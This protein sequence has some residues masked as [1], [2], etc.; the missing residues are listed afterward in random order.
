MHHTNNAYSATTTPTN[1]IYPHWQN[2]I[3]INELIH[4]YYQVFIDIQVF[5]YGIY[6]YERYLTMYTVKNLFH[7]LFSF[8]CINDALLIEY[9]R[10][11]FHPQLQIDWIMS[12]MTFYPDSSAVLL[13]GNTLTCN[14]NTPWQSLCLI[15]YQTKRYYKNAIIYCTEKKKKKTKMD[16][17]KEIFSIM[18]FSF[19]PPHTWPKQYVWLIR[20]QRGNMYIH[21]IYIGCIIL[22]GYWFKYI[23]VDLFSSIQRI[24]RWIKIEFY[25][26]SD[27][28]LVSLFISTLVERLSVD[29]NRIG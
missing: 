27:L 25:Q 22:Y 24:D 1:D 9:L 29:V 2:F 16:K 11:I 13:W 14:V 12:D 4:I 18:D 15:W 21:I 17:K 20:W 10:P 19:K 6:Q 5:L 28:L 3:W 8:S 26:L 7:N 23:L